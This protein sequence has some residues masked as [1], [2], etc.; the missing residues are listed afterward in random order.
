MR[1]PLAPSL[2]RYPSGPPLGFGYR[3]DIG[4][5]GASTDHEGIDIGVP[6][7]TPVYAVEDGTVVGTTNSGGPGI[8]ILYQL[9][10]A[11]GRML[12]T[13]IRCNHLSRRHV[14]VGD[15]VREG[16]IIGL[17]GNTGASGG[18]HLHFAVYQH[19][20]GAWRA[21]DP[22]PW[23]RAGIPAGGDSDTFFTPTE[24]E[25]DEMLYI[26]QREDSAK[27]KSLY[28]V[29][30][31][32]AIRKISREENSAFRSMESRDLAVFITVSDKEYVER[33]GAD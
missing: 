7:G 25:E 14:G 24:Q 15:R 8:S 20:S 6:V 10:D 22:V 2:M 31:G 33:G 28:D 26:L 29:T 19:W 17:S 9:R 12:D 13:R 5:P 32:R 21:T 4:V 11:F 18:P 30:K 27:A 1:T 3:G 23:L 16:Q